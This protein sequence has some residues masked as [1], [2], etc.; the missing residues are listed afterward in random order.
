MNAQKTDIEQKQKEM[1]IK[2][3]DEHEAFIYIIKELQN[4]L[5]LS[6]LFTHNQNNLSINLKNLMQR[7]ENNIFHQPFEKRKQTDKEVQAFV[8]KIFET[9]INTLNIEYPAKR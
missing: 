5:I 3:F 7:V 8:H 1:L 2:L 9:S 4:L 6:N